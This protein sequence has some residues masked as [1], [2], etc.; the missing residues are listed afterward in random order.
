M[1]LSSGSLSPS[2]STNHQSYYASVSNADNSIQITAITTASTSSVLLNNNPLSSNVAS[3]SI[4]LS[5]GNNTIVIRVT[6][7]DTVTFTTYTVVINR[8]FCKK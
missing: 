1:T 2:F 6:A 7:E 8:A 5:V 4:S 3:N